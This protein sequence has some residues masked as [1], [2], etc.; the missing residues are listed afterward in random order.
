MVPRRPAHHLTLVAGERFLLPGAV[1]VRW[2]DRR[3]RRWAAGFARAARFA[4]LFVSNVL[5]AAEL[6]GLVLPGGAL[7]DW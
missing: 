1:S 3:I 6:S 2:A 7:C 5:K 4:E